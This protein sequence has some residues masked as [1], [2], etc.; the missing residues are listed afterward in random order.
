MLIGIQEQP[1]EATA[2]WQPRSIRR[3]AVRALVDELL[4]YPKPGLVS[5]IDSGSHADMNSTTFIRSSLALRHFF[6]RAAE[7]GRDGC[8]FERLRALGMA[9]EANMLAATRGI[10][11]HRGAIFQ[12]GLL[13]AAAGKRTSSNLAVWAHQRRC[14]L[15]ETVVDEWADDIA[16]HQGRSQSHGRR[17]LSRFGAGG[18]QAEAASGFPSVYELA[19]PAY[20]RVLNAGGAP[21]QARVQAFFA[22]MARL[23]DTNLLHRGGLHGL[24]FAQRQGQDFLDRGGVEASDWR[25]EAVRIHHRFVARQ[26]SPG[27][28]ADLLA[29]CLFVD[30]V[31]KLEAAGFTGGSTTFDH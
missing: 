20:R 17:A 29:A 3:A 28:S 4:T 1:V 15:G 23:D 5:L 12:L 18:A 27:G 22:L 31:E 2:D 6:E 8:R 7:A 30:A 14:R 24:R 16:S 9:A 10:N 21:N 25:D 19:L 11:T 26:L 13:A